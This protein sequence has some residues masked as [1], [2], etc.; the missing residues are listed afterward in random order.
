M[1]VVDAITKKTGPL[2]E[3][4]SYTIKDKSKQA[5]IEDIVILDRY[6]VD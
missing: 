6:N 3:K 5:V 2:G 4:D 1:D